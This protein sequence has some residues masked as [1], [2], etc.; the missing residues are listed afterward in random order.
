M[1]AQPCL[2]QKKVSEVCIAEIAHPHLWIGILCKDHIC[3]RRIT[4]CWNQPGSSLHDLR[5]H[6]QHSRRHARG[7]P[8]CNAS[9]R[10]GH[11]RQQYWPAGLQP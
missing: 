8:A 4:K 6:G 3:H 10:V 1:L 2:H 11:A 9:C 5:K 7:T